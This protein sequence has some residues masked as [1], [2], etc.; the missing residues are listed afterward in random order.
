VAALQQLLPDHSLCSPFRQIIDAGTG[1]HFRPEHNQRWAET[2]R[3]MLEAFFH[4]HYFLEMVVKYGRTSSRQQ[5]PVLPSGW[6]AVL[7]LYG[8]R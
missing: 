7:T 5:P 3:P 2:T 8:L 1:K 6:A 4:A